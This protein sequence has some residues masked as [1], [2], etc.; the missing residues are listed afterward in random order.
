M[1]ITS[2]PQPSAG[3]AP[4]LKALLPRE[5][6]GWFLFL[7]PV[8]VGLG[9]AGQFNGRGDAF[10][11]AA[12]ALFCARQP[13]GMALKSWRGKRT[14][15]DLPLLLAWLAVCALLMAAT[16]AYLLVV[17]RLWGLL[18]LGIVGAGLLALQLWAG[19][20]RLARTL[21]SEVIGAAGL[22]LAAAGAHYAAIGAWTITTPVLWLQMAIVGV[23]GVPYSRW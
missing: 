9:V 23:G 3:P 19:S 14:L 13:L 16:S 11:V 7:V 17:A 15:A 18:P 8:A 10:V 4:R 12:L 2:P 22:A 6:G 21:W 1:T 20:A 5:H